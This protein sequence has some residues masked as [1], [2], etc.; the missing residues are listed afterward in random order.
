MSKYSIRAP[1]GKTYTIDG[2]D[3]ATDDQVRAEVLRQYPEAIG[4]EAPRFD[5]MSFPDVKVPT[6][7]DPQ[8]QEYLKR[9]WQEQPTGDL[10]NPETGDVLTPG[11]S[12]AERANAKAARPTSFLQGVGEGIEKPWNN[13]AEWV[14]DGLN[15]LKWTDKAAETFGVQSGEGFGDWING[16]G[17]NIGMAPSVDAARR[18]QEMARD[19]S[20]YQSSGVG[21]FAGEATGAAL[22]SRLPGGPLSQGAQAG[23]LLTDNPN[24]PYAVATDAVTGAV[25]GKVGDNVLRGAALLAAPAVSPALRTLINAG[26]KVTPGQVGRSISGRIGTAI[27]RTEDRAMSAPFVGDTITAARN[28]TLDDFARATINRAVNP[29][30]LSL[31]EN[32]P[33][34]RA[35]VKWAGDKLSEAYKAISPRVRVDGNDPQFI[36][37]LTSIADETKTMLP[38]RARQFNSIL[39]GL[40]RYW[41]NNGT[42][43]SG[44]AFKAVD[45]RLTSNISRYSTSTD[46][47]Q[48]Q[49]GQM[50]E[51]VRDALYE[52][53]S[54][55]NPDVA[56][57]MRALNQGWKSLTQVERASGN[58]KA[59]VSPSGY[60]QAVKLSSDTVRRRGYARGDALNQ[61]LSDAASAILPSDIA[62]SG[63]AGRLAQQSTLQ[64]LIGLAQIPGYRAAQK[65]TP[66]LLRQSATSPRLAQLLRYAALGSPYAAPALESDLR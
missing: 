49:L 28:S 38:E 62:D 50:L 32:V 9:G 1:N 34:G 54:R 24:D 60:S 41:R 13:A 22:L 2:P 21:K 30:G 10:L 18:N 39:G 64:N 7:D 11:L 57:E 20:Q 48:R 44:D 16:L 56:K 53:A 19:Q 6:K 45:E 59:A 43:L 46:A 37:D 66:L 42:V 58:S 23:A 63:T 40:E 26:V 65:V 51:S 61:D 8:Y 29:I 36:A 17:S 14:T 5:P 12:P 4:T 47:D 35:A 55:Q 25:A 31:P 15:N 3:G 33:V 52:T 27:A